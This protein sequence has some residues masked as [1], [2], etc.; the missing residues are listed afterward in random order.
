MTLTLVGC[1]HRAPLTVSLED[2][3]AKAKAEV[4]ARLNEA[5]NDSTRTAGERSQA[6]FRLFRG[7]IKPGSSVQD[8]PGVLTEPSWLERTRIHGAYVV[9]GWLPVDWD[10]FKD[11]AFVLH[12]FPE[13]D[14]PSAWHIYFTL[15]G[16]SQRPERSAMEI[17]RGQRLWDTNTRLAEFALCYPDGLIEKVTAEGIHAYGH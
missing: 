16:A 11:T 7:F 9:T 13:G 6:V 17:L 8:I 10:H 14:K 4:I 15:S 3:N 5:A 1:A 12:L 2:H